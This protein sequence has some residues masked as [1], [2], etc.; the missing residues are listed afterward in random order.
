MLQNRKESIT[1]IIFILLLV[2]SRIIVEIPNFTPTVA[3]IMFAS[4]LLKDKLSFIVCVIFS[5]IISDAYLGFYDGMLFTYL[6][7]L[8]IGFATSGLVKELKF[9]KILFMAVVS[10]VLFF[11]ITNFGVWYSMDLYQPSFEGLTHS[12][13]AGIPFLKMT[14][15]A[16]ILYS[17]TI[18]VIYKY[19]I[20]MPKSIF[21]SSKK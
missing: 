11:L 1:I 2:L 5:Q 20:H 18:Y 14:M 6:A 7:Y 3:L 10:P 9:S 16:T 4:V 19:I 13:V 17:V 8:I 21:K 15:T 12:Y